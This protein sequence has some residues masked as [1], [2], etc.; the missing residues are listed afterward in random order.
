MAVYTMPTFTA[1]QPVLASDLATL[2]AAL[3]FIHNPPIAQLR[4][5]TAQALGTSGTFF[6]I[7]FDAEVVDSANGHSTSTNPSRYVAQYAGYYEISGGVAFVANATGSRFVE[8][9]VNG[10][11][12]GGG[13]ASAPASAGIGLWL[14]A[15][16][17]KVF[18]N[19]G[20]YVELWGRQ[21]SGGSLN[22]DTGSGPGKSSMTV[23]WV[24]N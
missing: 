7:T 6:A 11:A 22:T 21:D 18:L 10:S 20:D 13:T 17:T 1:G 19:V 23:E 3:T 9:A 2:S 5:D 14:A 12:L 24:S 16:D 4:Q 8:I 15:R